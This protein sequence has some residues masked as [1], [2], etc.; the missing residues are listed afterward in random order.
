MNR[1]NRNIFIAIILSILFHI[2]L[3]YL[4]D[5]FD[6]LN[7]KMDQIAEK[8]PEKITLV[9]PENK[10]EPK[11][12]EMLIVE[13]QNENEELPQQGNLLSDKNSRA[14]NDPSTALNQFNTP[15]SRGNSPLQNLS[16]PMRQE[17][18][19][20]PRNK[21]FSKDAL[22][23]KQVPDFSDQKETFETDQQ[24]SQ[25]ASIGSNQFM[26]Q[27]KFSV[28]EVGALSLSTYAWE[29]APYINK[30]KQKHSAV[31]FAPPAYSRLG[32]IHGQTVIVFEI[33]RDGSLVRAEVIDHKGHESL[34]I[35]SFESIRAVFPFLPLPVDFPDETLTITA[36][37]IYP[38]LKK[39]YN[40]RRR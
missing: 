1:R 32:I 5:F 31:W 12:D 3:I 34:Q 36:T 23:G 24:P 13:N 29:W 14:Q 30:L 28:E 9:F 2:G 21:P 35:S 20:T 10:P 39:L 8:I 18:Q 19:F 11:K 26:N 7:I 40:E 16:G 33:A 6:W 25:Q 22:T 4:I 17:Q 27:E 38:D 37:L 15:F